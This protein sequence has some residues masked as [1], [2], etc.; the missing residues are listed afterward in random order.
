MRG[1]QV[2]TK[3]C[4]FGDA[5]RKAADLSYVEQVGGRACECGTGG[6]RWG[7]GLG[8]WWWHLHCTLTVAGKYP[9]ARERKEDFCVCEPLASLAVQ[10]PADR[11]AAGQWPSHGWQ[12]AGPGHAATERALSFRDLPAWPPLQ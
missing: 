4:C 1:P 10:G 5:M 7:S 2:L 12:R 11:T 6:K 3:F 9:S 8:V